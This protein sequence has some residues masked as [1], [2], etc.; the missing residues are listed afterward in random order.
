MLF[1]TCLLFQSNLSIRCSEVYS[2]LFASS[3]AWHATT[4]LWH[5]STFL[6]I[7]PEVFLLGSDKWKS[8]AIFLSFFF[9]RSF[10]NIWHWSQCIRHG[11]L[12]RTMN[13]S[14]TQGLARLGTQINDVI[15]RSKAETR[16]RKIALSATCNWSHL[17]ISFWDVTNTSILVLLKQ[18]QMPF[19]T[20]LDQRHGSTFIHHSIHGDP[21]HWH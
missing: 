4:T 16:F 5:S 12:R 14:N 8:K 20:H 15:E 9:Q 1:I 21:S 17:E 18:C 2:C 6:C 7:S 11:C 19:K 3:A 13:D 10:E